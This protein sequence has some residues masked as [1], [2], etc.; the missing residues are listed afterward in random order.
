MAISKI[1][2]ESLDLTDNYA[3]T[4]TVTGAGESN[5]PIFYGELSSGKTLSRAVLTKID[6]L[7]VTDQEKLDDYIHPDSMS[8]LE[9]FDTHSAGNKHLRKLASAT[10]SLVEEY[11]LVSWLP[12]NGNQEDSVSFVLSQIDH[13][14]QFGEDEDVKDSMGKFDADD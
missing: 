1:I 8:L 12:L 2:S 9:E 14:L 13:C 6:L 11:S 7:S 5:S 4:G 3:F 10:A